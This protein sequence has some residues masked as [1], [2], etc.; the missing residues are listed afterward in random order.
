MRTAAIAALLLLLLITSLASAQTSSHTSSHTETISRTSIRNNLSSSS[1]TGT[2]TASHS[3]YASPVVYD[4]LLQNMGSTDL[5]SFT[6]KIT[7]TLPIGQISSGNYPGFEN[8]PRCDSN[9]SGPNAKMCSSAF[10]ESLG[11]G[12]AITLTITN[13]TSVP[14]TCS[15]DNNLPSFIQALRDADEVVENSI[16]EFSDDGLRKVRWT[17]IRPVKAVAVFDENTIVDLTVPE[18]LTYYNEECFFEY[19]EEPPMPTP[20]PTPAGKQSF[21]LL[22]PVVTTE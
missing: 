12:E 7:N 8:D 16:E 21:L 6:V 1:L 2:I 15:Y 20:V 5:I 9:L 19:I 18:P 14:A 10:V 4:M 22:L 17:S 11:A 3:S 13:S